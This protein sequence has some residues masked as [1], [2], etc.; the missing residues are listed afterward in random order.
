[1]E[2]SV[3]AQ[4]A[5]F[6]QEARAFFA[7]SY[8]ED[9]RG[10][11]FERPHDRNFFKAV[12][13]WQQQHLAGRD[14][15]EVSAFYQEA[16]RSGIE[17][18]THAPT[19]M[20]AETLEEVGTE[21][22]KHEIV[23][24]LRGGEYLIALGLTEPDAG[25]DLAA[26]RTR[27]VRDGEEWVINGQKMY[28]SNAQH[29]TH[30]FLLTRTNTEAPKHQGLTVFLVPIDAPGVE[31]RPLHTLAYHHTNMTFYD[32]V[33]VSDTNRIGEIDD[34]WSV[35]KVALSREQA[36]EG[37]TD[38][39]ELVRQAILWAEGTDS[40]ESGRMIDDPIV[41]D[42][43]ARAAIDLEVS[44]LLAQRSAWATANGVTKDPGWGPGSKLFETEA[45]V[46]TAA[47][48][49]G[50]VG[51]AA[52]VPFEES[53]TVSGGW[54]NYCFRDS[55][56]RVIAGGASE[57]MREIIAERRLGLPRARPR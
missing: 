54:F 2:F 36:G 25:S 20:I 43:I 8:P 23:P 32:D 11:R 31:V 3:P 56:V 45:Y 47:D 49:F 9:L 15:Y 37:S 41:R 40:P 22:Q 51:P 35:M 34:G 30:V 19:R 10:R 28:T 5:P 52:V 50:M 29:A 16:A 55:P 46:R 42:R 12:S 17:M 48:F 6:R 14:A 39:H 33:R 18:T 13:R 21:L 7:S 44:T 57:V 53:G 1:M 26:A 24:L 4:A 27:A 38:L